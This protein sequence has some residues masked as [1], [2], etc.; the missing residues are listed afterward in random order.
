MLAAQTL[1]KRGSGDALAAL[2][3]VVDEGF[4]PFLAAQ[5]V[6]SATQIAGAQ[7]L[8]EWL[9]VL[10]HSRSFLVRREACSALQNRAASQ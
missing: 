7:A 3:R 10:T 6:R 5:A 9:T 2:R 1:G 8:A 4:D